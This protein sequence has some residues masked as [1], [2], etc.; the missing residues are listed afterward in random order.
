MPGYLTGKVAVVIGSGGEAHR[1]VAVALAEAGAEL[2]IAGPAG[3][4]SAEASLHSIANEIWAMGRRSSVVML[5][6]DDAPAFG[7]AI[8]RVIAE[9]G[10]ADVVV[11]CEPVLHS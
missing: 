6:S 1:G 4:L 3:D 5:T 10:R 8:A 2:A 9:L 11:R 7:E